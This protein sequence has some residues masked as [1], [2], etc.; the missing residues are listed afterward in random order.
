MFTQLNDIALKAFLCGRAMDISEAIHYKKLRTL[1]LAMTGVVIP[2][3]GDGDL[4]PTAE[5]NGRAYET[6]PK[7]FRRYRSIFCCF[8]IDL[9]D[10]APLLEPVA[11]CTKIDGTKRNSV[12]RERSSINSQHTVFCCERMTGCSYGTTFDT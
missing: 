6:L 2:A 7:R 5:K 1:R 12:A 3:D 4:R 8:Q 10:Y 11:M 9:F